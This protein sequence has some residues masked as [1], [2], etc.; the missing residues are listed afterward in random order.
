MRMSNPRRGPHR[1]SFASRRTP[2]Q[3]G[4][5]LVE[6]LI[7]AALLLVI[8]VSVLP[9]F[10]RALESN[11]SGGRSSQ[12]ST[13]VST[14]LEGVNQEP[15]D[16]DAWDVGGTGT[17][18]LDL[19]DDFF[20]LGPSSPSLYVGDEKW[21]DTEADATGPGS[22]LWRRNISVRKYSLADVQILVGAGGGLVTAG[23]SPMLFDA[24]LTD[25]AEAHLAEIRV[26][27]KERRDGVPA[28][29]GKR[30]T[31]GHFRAF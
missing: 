5:S 29:S 16:Q 12:L 10:M 24:P 21:V 17:G 14:D 23:E 7:A 18:V 26:T 9:I 1:A 25:D 22:L 28:A 19:G 11:L 3:A 2:R 6:G 30:V 20:D 27:I 13:F 31:T 15:V 8:A 4:F